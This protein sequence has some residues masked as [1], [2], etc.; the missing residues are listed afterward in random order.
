MAMVLKSGT[1]KL[2]ASA[3]EF[4]RNDAFRRA[5]TTL[6]RRRQKSGRAATKMFFGFN[7]GGPVTSRKAL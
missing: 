2:H 3:W 6:I 7:V 5:A 4:N 1:S